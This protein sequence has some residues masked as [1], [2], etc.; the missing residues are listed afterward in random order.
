MEDAPDRSAGTVTSSRTLTFSWDRL[1][2]LVLLAVLVGLVA[3]GLT[4]AK[5]VREG[6]RSRSAGESAVKAARTEVLALTTIGFDTS[7]AGIKRILDGA[8]QG[9]RDQFEDQAKAF[10]AALTDSKVTS[11]GDVA[12]AGLTKLAGDKAEVLVAATGT[13]KNKDT[14]S[15]QPRNY[16]LRV[17]LERVDGDWLVSNME[18]V[19]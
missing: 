14:K 12:S 9:F 2:G 7:D 19:A 5:D 18:F 6:A 13:I 8:T 3:F 4:C 1:V 17:D 11:T 10:R 16:R 15:S